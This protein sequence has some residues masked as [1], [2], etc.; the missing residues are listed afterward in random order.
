MSLWSGSGI[1]LLRSCPLRT[2]QAS[3]PAYGSSLYKDPCYRSRSFAIS[4][5]PSLSHP[6][7]FDTGGLQDVRDTPIEALRHPIVARTTGR[8]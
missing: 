1:A 6:G 3:F 7:R 8:G 5:R 2:V 4:E